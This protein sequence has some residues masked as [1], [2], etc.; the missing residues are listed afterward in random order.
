[1]KKYAFI[2]GVSLILVIIQSSFVVIPNLVFALGYALIMR[3]LYDYGMV[4]LLL[5]G[6]FLDF[7]LLTNYGV[8]S[9]TF[10]LFAQISF[11]IKKHF[12]DG[13]WIH[14][15]IF[16]GFSFLY[17]FV[18][19]ETGLHLQILLSLLSA[20]FLLFLYWMLSKL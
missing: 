2:A 5:G 15:F 3:G 13:F 14:V 4:S 11:W 7:F 9:F 1:M 8:S 6:L 16:I 20:G 19:L 17:N 12:F 18:F 10:V